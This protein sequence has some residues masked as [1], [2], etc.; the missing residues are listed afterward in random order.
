MSFAFCPRDGTRL[1]A[2]HIDGRLR[3]AC[4]TC[5]FADFRHVQIGA[6][7]IVERDGQVLLIRL[8][9]GPRE[10]HWALPGGMVESDESLEQAALRET[11]EETGFEVALDGLVTTWI[12]PGF[13]LLVL[14]YRAHVLR[15]ELKLPPE[16]ASEGRWFPRNALPPI[17]ELAWPSHAHGLATWLA[18]S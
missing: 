15:G 10:G 5:G 7:T 16:E 4:P 18:T 14:V 3:P 17:H 6:N 2:R 8:A 1:E 9:Y 13:D 11:Q 12:R